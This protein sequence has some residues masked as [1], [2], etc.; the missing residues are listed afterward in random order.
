VLVSGG[1]FEALGIQPLAGRLIGANE[2][3]PGGD[4]VA[5]L[6]ESLWRNHFGASTSAVGKTMRINNELYTIVGILPR[7]AEH[8]EPALFWVPLRLT[9]PQPG[10]PIHLVRVLGRLKPGV[11]LQAAQAE[12]QLLATQA[13]QQPTGGPIDSTAEVVSL[14]ERLVGNV[15]QSLLLLWAA[16][17]LVLLLA[18]AN[19]AS[20]LLARLSRRTREVSLKLSLGARRLRL[21]R[22]FLIESMLLALTGALAGLGIGSRGAS[23]LLRLFPEGLPRAE[24][25]SLDTAT[26]S[27]TL[28]I[29][30]LAAI[31][32][33]TLPALRGT[34]A[35]LSDLLKSAARTAT[36]AVSV[37]RLQNALVVCQF[38]L[39][40]VIAFNAALLVRTFLNLRGVDPGF[41]SANLLT[42]RINLS[43]GR[44]R[45]AAAQRAFWEVLLE[46]LSAVPGVSR[47][48]L[49]DGLPLSPFRGMLAL[50]SVEGQPAWEPDEAPRHRTGLYSISPDFFPALNIPVIAGRPL[51]NADAVSDLQPV[52]INEALAQRAFAGGSPLGKRLKLGDPEGPG[53]WLTIVGVVGN[54]K[55]GGLEEEDQP[56]IYWPYQQISGLAAATLI[57]Q[58]E[59]EPVAL[60]AVV[61][62]EV[63]Q[64][65]P[66]QP[67]HDVATMRERLAH[68]TAPQ[69]ERALLVGAFAVLALTLA[70]A[71]V[72]GVLSHL[73]ARQ[74]S[75]FGV[76]MALGARASDLLRLVLKR[77]LGPAS[78]GVGIGLAATAALSRFVES[79][80]FGV[81]ATDFAAVLTTILVLLVVA[82]LACYLPA[83][84]ASKLDP[85]SA[86]R[87]E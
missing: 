12:L 84:R 14:H 20:L 4:R 23:W 33:G 38:G 73:V 49:S 52:V 41:A 21:V 69:R 80:L 72:F 87:I 59:H 65:D 71:G 30:A 56:M 2:H 6:G 44:N 7:S 11:S 53:R 70:G 81:R 31:V 32:F 47:V 78:L 26:L 37:M 60:I 28:L 50:F 85:V 83:R 18:C 55:Q 39:A 82:A 75:E 1:Y 48:S 24:T 13:R 29:A 8:V 17:A 36:G 22:Q 5:L 43:G 62:H 68:T 86:L 77:G 3:A 74:T 57:V 63:R 64:I 58:T 67:I 35:N 46:R 15:R 27:F 34:K 19:V 25:V 40:T 42:A 45:D 61:R 76:R 54:V 16:V 10:Q 79:L 66:A 51:D 9:I